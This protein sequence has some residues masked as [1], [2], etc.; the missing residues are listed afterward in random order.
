K[1]ETKN[2]S[3]TIVRSH[4]RVFD[5]LGRLVQSIGAAG[6][7]NFLTY[8]GNGNILKA[9]DALHRET[10][11][12]FD[13]LDRLTLVTDPLANRIEQGFDAQDNLVSVKDPRSL[14]TIFH[15]DGFGRVLQEASPDR[16][17]TTYKLDE[18]NNPIEQRDARGIVVL[19]A[20]DKINRLISET[21]PT[22]P[23]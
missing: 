11:Q 9:W 19:R 20:F 21:Y 8:D 23:S 15:R 7:T 22:S 10:S 13:P 2:G 14:A 1:E 16:G 17:I 3:G 12:F 4:R 5:E 6:Q 18:A